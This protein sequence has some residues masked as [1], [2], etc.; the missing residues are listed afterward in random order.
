MADD[1]FY[2]TREWLDL[3]YRVLQKQGGSCQLCGC[4]ASTDNPIQVD[5]IKPRSRHPELALAESNMQVLCKRCNHGKS[6]KDSTDWRWKASQELSKGINRRTQILTSASPTQKAKLEQL[7]WL[8][9]NDVDLQIRREA[10]KQYK[11]LW[12]E[13]EADWLAKGQPES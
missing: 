3:R 10:E 5:H 9:Q 11:T 2:E 6:N 4:R 13:I 1:G 7:G 8:R 12:Q